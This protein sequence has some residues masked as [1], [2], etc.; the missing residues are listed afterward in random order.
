MEVREKE[1]SDLF[2]AFSLTFDS[3]K[4]ESEKEREEVNKILETERKDIEDI[5]LEMKN[6]C[7]KH[8]ESEKNSKLISKMDYKV[9]NKL[10]ENAFRD[11]GVYHFLGT[12]GVFLIGKEG[13]SYYMKSNFDLIKN[14]EIIFKKYSLGVG[15]VLL[16]PSVIKLFLNKKKSQEKFS[17]SGESIQKKSIKNENEEELLENSSDQV[18]SLLVSFLKKVFLDNKIN[19]KSISNKEF[20]FFEPK[21]C[22]TYD[23]FFPH[24]KLLLKKLLSFKNSDNN[25]EDCSLIFNHNILTHSEK[26]SE[27]AIYSLLQLHQLHYEE[28]KRYEESVKT[29]YQEISDLYHNLKDRLKENNKAIEECKRRKDNPTWFDFQ[30]EFIKYKTQYPNANFIFAI[31]ES[32]T[33]KKKRIKRNTL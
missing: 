8:I 10:K 17:S 28:I 29:K 30:C 12:S 20:D 19:E 13:I 24:Y 7:N 11:F 27:G 33:Y 3:F 22:C 25:S 32:S 2:N 31:K 5:L 18:K 4:K 23:L 21:F 15:C 6:S 14:L 16:I 1:F 26:I 9:D